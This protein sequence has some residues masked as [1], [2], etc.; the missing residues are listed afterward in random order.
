MVRR[1]REPASLDDRLREREVA[2]HS[3]VAAFLEEDLRELTDGGVAQA[4]VV[5]LRV[6]PRH[7]LVGGQRVRG[8]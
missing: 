6:E 8:P 4:G 1:R 7:H 5:A 3:F 2:A